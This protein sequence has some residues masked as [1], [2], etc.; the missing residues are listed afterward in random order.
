MDSGLRA[1]R[2]ESRAAKAAASARRCMPILSN[3]FDT[4]FLTVF[5]AKYSCSPICRLTSLGQEFENAPFLG[6]DALHGRPGDQEQ[7]AD[8]AW[9]DE[10]AERGTV[11]SKTDRED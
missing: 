11:V 5:S 9:R 8:R 1:W 2:C 6:R 7:R 10:T 4:Q 3:R